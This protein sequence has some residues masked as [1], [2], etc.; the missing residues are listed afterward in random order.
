MR[1]ADEEDADGRAKEPRASVRQIKT[2]IT[3][4]GIYFVWYFVC[5]LIWVNKY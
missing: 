1:Q 4:F 3:F 5:N 2:E